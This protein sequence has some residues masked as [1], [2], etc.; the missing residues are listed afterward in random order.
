[1]RTYGRVWALN[2]DGSRQNPQPA[3]FPYWQEVTTD[4]N[5]FSD[6]VWL[7]TLAQVLQLNLNES[8]FYANYGLPDEQ[9]IMQQVAPDF[10][11]NRTQQQFAQY[12][13]SLIIARVPGTV[14]PTYNVNVLTNQGARQVFQV[15]T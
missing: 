11:V 7:T 8:P 15:P 3:G 14:D 10:Y 6:S 4:A 1:M 9:S 12:F 13:A 5:G 2:E